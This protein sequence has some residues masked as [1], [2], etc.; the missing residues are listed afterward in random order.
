MAAF[1]GIALVAGVTGC[2][3]S[4]DDDEAQTVTVTHTTAVTETPTWLPN[5]DCHPPEVTSLELTWERKFGDGIPAA[6]PEDAATP[7]GYFE[8]WEIQR[9]K[10]GLRN[11]SPNRIFTRGVT[12]VA[13]W[14]DPDKDFGFTDWHPGRG[15]DTD[16]VG[17]VPR[18]TRSSL[19]DRDPDYVN[20]GDSIGFDR[21]YSN[22]L[23][24]GISVH[25]YRGKPLAAWVQTIDWWFAE[26]DVR[27]RCHQPQASVPAETTTGQAPAPSIATSPS[28]AATSSAVPVPPSR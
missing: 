26:P 18:N 21:S 25:T 23:G 8:V 6:L 10:V 11:L 28:S 24:D 3:S 17:D 22:A 9:A 20:P 19:I 15:V 2:G 27:A 16:P 1:T 4:D 5:L 12:F 7:V 14:L 13:R